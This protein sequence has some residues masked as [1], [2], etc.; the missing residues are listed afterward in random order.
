MLPLKGEK[1]SI[2]DI[3]QLSTDPRAAVALKRLSADKA[4]DAVATLVMWNVG[5]MAWENVAELFPVIAGLF[6]A[7]VEPS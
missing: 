3:G 1:L 5:G 7:H 4:P 6:C 2:G